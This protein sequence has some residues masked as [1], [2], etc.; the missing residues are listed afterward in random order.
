MQPDADGTVRQPEADSQDTNDFAAMLAAHRQQP[1]ATPHLVVLVIHLDRFT[2]ANETLGAQPALRLR[3]QAAA[4]IAALAHPAEIA[5]LGQAD[6]GVIV[7]LPPGGAPPME[8]ALRLGRSVGAGLARPFQQDGFELFLSSSIGVAMDDPVKPAERCLHEAYDAMLRVRKRGGDGVA[9]DTAAAS[10]PLAT[11]LLAA[12]PYALARGQLSLNLQAR[13]S[14]ATACVTGYTVRLRWQSPELGRVAPQDFLPA[15]EALGLMGD[16]AHWLMENALPM[17]GCTGIPSPVALSFP[18]S[19][20]QLHGTPMIDTLLRTLEQEQ[21]DPARVCLEIPAA[22]LPAG[23]R[24]AAGKLA[25][26]R[27]AGLR[28]ALSDFAEAPDGTATLER[29]QPDLLTFNAR[30][31]G[32]ADQAGPPGQRNAAVARLQAACEQAQRLA[33][34]VC[35]RGIETRLQLGVVRQWGCSDMQGYL[36]AQPFPVHWLAQTHAAI[37]ARARELLG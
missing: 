22:A 36:L 3:A 14:L 25:R 28:F 21:F 12:L 5:W 29:L 4:R 13:A 15:L 1:A 18:V 17:L 33:L 2:H 32:N 24:E 6:I 30:S 37:C 10:P 27:R 9:G 35:A 16:V 11:P 26:L 8:A 23:D 31:I 20:A 7:A 19:S 34:P